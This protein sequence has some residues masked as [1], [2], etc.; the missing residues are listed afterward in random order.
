MS[1]MKNNH[2]RKP[3]PPPSVPHKLTVRAVFDKL[4]KEQVTEELN[5]REQ[6]WHSDPAD[7]GWDWAG[8]SERDQGL[9]EIK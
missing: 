8:P 3:M 9:W 4:A 7:E 2:M 1:F 6:R 5:L